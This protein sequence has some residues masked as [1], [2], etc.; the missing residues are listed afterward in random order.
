MTLR[1]M[2]AVPFDTCMSASNGVLYEKELLAD[3]SL[4]DQIIAMRKHFTTVQSVMNCILAY[5][6]LL[7]IGK[8][9]GIGTSESEL[10]PK[11]IVGVYSGEC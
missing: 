8:S 7:L 4:K 3:K 6:L 2:L 11:T 10:P 5:D 1:T 9:G